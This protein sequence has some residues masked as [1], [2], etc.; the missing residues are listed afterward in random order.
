MRTTPS[1]GPGALALSIVGLSS[2]THWHLTIT[3][4]IK[5]TWGLKDPNTP[6]HS[7]ARGRDPPPA[8]VK[9]AEA[10]SLARDFSHG[11]TAQS[12]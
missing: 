8:G 11:V 2:A 9:L 1:P 12:P 3:G 10:R 4:C 7:F 5:E 6:Q